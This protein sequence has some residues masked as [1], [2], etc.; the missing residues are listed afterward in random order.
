MTTILDVNYDVTSSV[1][2]ISQQQKILNLANKFKL[3]GAKPLA[4]PL[5]TGTDLC[6][7][8]GTTPAHASLKY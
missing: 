2:D 1:L 4:C 5:P 8:K 3:I 6:V 7:I